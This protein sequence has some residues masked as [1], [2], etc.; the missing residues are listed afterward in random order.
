MDIFYFSKFRKFSF[1][2]ILL[3]TDESSNDYR[4]KKQLTVFN[5]VSLDEEPEENLNEIIEAD[6]IKGISTET[7]KQK[8]L[9]SS[10]IENTTMTHQP[11]LTN[12]DQAPVENETTEEN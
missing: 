1:F 8:N 7:K 3:I 4:D 6:F 9:E 12:S 11:E 2:K 10:L 5:F